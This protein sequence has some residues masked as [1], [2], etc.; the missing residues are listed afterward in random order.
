MYF[1]INIL[2]LLVFLAVGWVFSNNRKDIKWKSVG[3][4]VVLNL[5]IAFLLTSFEAGLP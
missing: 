2:G 4:M 1:A 5:V 3:C